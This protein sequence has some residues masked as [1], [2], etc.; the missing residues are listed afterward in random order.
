[1]IFPFKSQGLIFLFGSFSGENRPVIVVGNKV[2]L[3]PG[4][5]HGYLNR[6]KQALQKSLRTNGLG[7]IKLK[8]VIL[9][10]ARSGFGVEDLIT[11]VHRM[12]EY[13]GEQENHSK[14]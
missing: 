3:L 6:I 11:E 2:D 4:T 8:N 5:H 13:K 14:Q 1:V 10:S 12:L 9:I 7:N